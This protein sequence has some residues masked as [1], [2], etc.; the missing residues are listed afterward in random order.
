MLRT[1]SSLWGGGG[2]KTSW[3]FLAVLLTI[4]CGA[5]QMFSCELSHYLRESASDTFRRL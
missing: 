3:T 1:V 5:H 4:E 2:D